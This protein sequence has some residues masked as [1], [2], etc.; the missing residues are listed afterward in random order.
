MT[1]FLK[2]SVSPS[3]RSNPRL[4][5][6]DSDM[7]VEAVSG[8]A[9]ARDNGNERTPLLNHSLEEPCTPEQRPKAKDI[10]FRA[11]ALLYATVTALAVSMILQDAPAVRLVEIF[12][13][14]RFYE[15]HNPDLMGDNGVVDE[16]YCKIDVVQSQV[17]FLKGW[18]S[19]FKY[20]PGI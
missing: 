16:E 5:S 2:Y 19:F 8:D 7:A 4:K 3:S 11:L 6:L 1:I 15:E 9:E 12:Y 18:L 10:R 17:A 13:C 20:L 14:R